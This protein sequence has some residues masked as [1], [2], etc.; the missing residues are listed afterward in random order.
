MKKYGFVFDG[1]LDEFNQTVADLEAARIP[2]VL[3]EKKDGRYAFGVGRAG[4]GGG[5][6]YSP[7]Y[8]ERDGKLYIEG[9]IKSDVPATKAGKVGRVLWFVILFP[10]HLEFFLL[11]GAARLIRFALRKENPASPGKTLRRL[12]IGRLK[13]EKT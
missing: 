10:V 3:F 4:H 9:T 5:Y 6:W 11:I 12:M 7:T 2:D 8:A 1:T 13:C